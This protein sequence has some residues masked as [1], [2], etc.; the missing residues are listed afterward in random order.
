[1][2]DLLFGPVGAT[3]VDQHSECGQADQTCLCPIANYWTSLFVQELHSCYFLGDQL[4]DQ[5]ISFI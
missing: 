4:F 2:Y 1:M 3:P 5:V